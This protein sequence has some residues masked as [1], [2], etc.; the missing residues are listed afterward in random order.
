MRLSLPVVT[1]LCLSSL[2]SPAAEPG[3]E[4][5]TFID[6]ALQSNPSLELLRHRLAAAEHRVPQAGA[7][8]DPMF[9]VDFSNVP[10]SDL[11]FA[12]SPM[13]GIQLSL[14]QRLPY[15]GKRGARQRMA[16]HAAAASQAAYR[17]REGVVA[18]LVKQSYYTI[19]FHDQAIDIT[20]ENEDLLRD[21][22]R[23][24]QTKYAVGTGLQQDVLKA[25]VSLSS[26]Q[27]RLISLRQQRRRA[28]A[29]LNA[30]LNRLPQA[31]V[32]RASLP[33][34]PLVHTTES[35]QDIALASRPA[36]AKLQAELAR[37]AAAEDLVRRESRPDFDLTVG[38]RQR[39]FDRDP[40]EG[41]DF[42]SAAVA[43]N[44][45]VYTGR[46]QDA[47]VREIQAQRRGT[48]A[49]YDMVRQRLFQDIHKLVIDAE[50]HR[51]EAALFKTVIIPQADQSL[52]AALAGYQVDKVD[53][54]ALLDSQV[55][56][57][58]FEI[59]YTRH[60]TGYEKSLAQLEAVVG[61][62]LFEPRTG[63]E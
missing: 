35:L 51:D 30:V 42:V 62:R 36:L 2:H 23:I 6:E 31:P 50:A 15:W 20:R 11:D 55:S 54:L 18:N 17:D 3:S 25:Q 27:D 9:K 7:L 40:V 14:S 63:D 57:L 4:L 10:L 60:R 29:D 39:S 52:S 33:L 13:T 5:E 41:S 26:L 8:M 21:F 61:Q 24:A 32:G 46:K 43:L 38:Y 58:N 53:F 48:Q 56:L 45:P 1:I 22:I 34:T 49:E 37:W 16:E 59:A 19:A 44:L 28:A 47:Q 12:S